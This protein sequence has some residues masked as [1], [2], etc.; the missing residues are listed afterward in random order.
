MYSDLLILLF[1]AHM[2]SQN[3]E[4]VISNLLTDV[5]HPPAGGYAD[6]FQP[7]PQTGADADAKHQRRIADLAD[8]EPEN[9]QDYVDPLEQ[10]SAEFSESKAERLQVSTA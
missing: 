6:S 10:A 2:I 7:S 8:P 5:C 3:R 4:F 9:L 1:S